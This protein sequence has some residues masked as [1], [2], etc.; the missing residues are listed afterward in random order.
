MLIW[1]TS[2]SNTTAESI[3]QDHKT[4]ATHIEMLTPSQLAV[5]TY[6]RQ[7]SGSK[8]ILVFV[9][10]GGGC[11]KSFLLHTVRRLFEY[12]FG[13]SATVLATSGSAAVLSNAQ[14]VFFILLQISTLL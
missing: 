11:G 9:T 4:L 12:Q 3:Q 5:F 10:G 8:Q 7:T 14:T 2:S 13:K 1:N 6:I